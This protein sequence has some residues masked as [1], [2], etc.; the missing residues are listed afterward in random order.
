MYRT[1]LERLRSLMGQSIQGWSTEP[2]AVGEVGD[3]YWAV[4]SGAPSPDVNLALVWSPAPDALRRPLDLIEQIGAP[5]LLNIAGDA[6]VQTIGDEWQPVG[7]MPFMAVDIGATPTAADPR[8]RRAGPADL[9]TVVDLL[10]ESYGMAPEIASVAVRPVVERTD[11]DAGIHFWLL[12][13]DDVAVSTV[14]T[15]QVD[16]IVSVW[17]MGTPG[18]FARRGY[19]RALLAH[20]L[21]HASRRRAELGLLGATPAGKPLYDNT[22]WQTL[23]EWQIY[24][25]ATDP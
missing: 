23:E 8:V 13:D 4:L 16:D 6:A 25:N 17:C 22:G 14:M 9:T 21:D 19:A 18:R 2:S 1:E 3:G 10:A 20:V 7:T 12:E 5:A 15:G 11:A 24:V